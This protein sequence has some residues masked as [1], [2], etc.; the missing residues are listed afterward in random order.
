MRSAEAFATESG[1]DR[2]VPYYTLFRNRVTGRNEF[3]LLR[4]FV[5][6]SRDDLRTEL[7]AFMT[8][9]RIEGIALRPSF[10]TAAYSASVGSR[11][12]A[13]SSGPG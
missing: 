10:A 1:V 7:Q 13:P 2:F 9:S 6:F 5:P 11:A 3:V 12:P 8:A 4:P